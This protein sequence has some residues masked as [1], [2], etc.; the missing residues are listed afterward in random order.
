MP[1]NPHVRLCK[2]IE[3]AVAFCAEWDTKRHLLG[4]DTDGV[5]VKANSFWLQQELGTNT[6]SPR[7]AIAFKYPAMQVRTQIKDI[8]VQVGRTGAI[9]PVAILQPVAVAGVVVARATLHNEDEIRRKDVRIGDTVVIQRA[10]EVIPEV[11]EVVVSERNGTEKE[12]FMP[13]ECPSCGQTLVKPAGEV[14]LRCPNPACPKKILGGL[15]HFASRGAMDIEG[16][17]DK[18]C[19]QLI[20]TG[21]VKSPS[22]LYFLHLQKENLLKLERMGE[23]LASKILENIEKSKTRP[24]ANLIFALGIRHI[25]DHSSDVLASHFGTLERIR[26]ASVEELSKVHEIG[27]TTAVSLFEWFAN[28]TNRETLDKLIEGGVS[29]RLHGMRIEQESAHTHH[30]GGDWHKPTG[31]RLRQPHGRNGNSNTL[32]SP[33]G[34]LPDT[35][36]AVQYG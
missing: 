6:R 8:E 1:T 23:K 36:R 31:N 11:V 13:T 27:N 28:E 3:E 20:L 16:L 33:Q 18:Q 30:H 5:V 21:L 2:G 22:D 9:T 35:H 14:V 7:W 29:H 17:G 25:G 4:Y 15:Q 12:F 10:G 26:A 24:L 32:F 19:E 34:P